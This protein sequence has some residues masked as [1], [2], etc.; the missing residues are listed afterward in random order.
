MLGPLRFRLHGVS[1]ATSAGRIFRLTNSCLEPSGDVCSGS[2]TLGVS[3]PDSSGSL[4]DW[5]GAQAIMNTPANVA[6]HP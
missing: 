6:A 2:P 1:L 3:S 5:V 4:F